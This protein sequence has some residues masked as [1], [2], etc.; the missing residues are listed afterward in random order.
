MLKQKIKEYKKV[1]EMNW[2]IRKSYYS[3][4]CKFLKWQY[5]NP[6]LKTKDAYEAKILRQAHV[7]EK[8]MSLSSPKKGFGV[9]K[10]LDLLNYIKE[11]TANG[12]RI[13]ES[14]AAINALGVLGAYVEFHKK[15]GFFPEEIENELKKYSKSI[16]D[17][18]DKFGVIESDL[19]D[20]RQLAQG[21]FQEFFKSRHSIRQFSKEPVTEEEINKAVS[22]AM[23]APS[24]CNRQSVKVYFYKDEATNKG[25]GNLIA[26]NTGFENETSRYIVITSNVS[27]FYESFER[28]QM[29]IDGGI[30]ALALSESLHYYGIANCILQNGE[31]KEKDD[32]FRKVCQNIPENE[33]I[34]VF[35]AVGHYPKQFT[36]ASSQRKKLS[37][38]LTIK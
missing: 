13:E 21:N 31:S 24:A 8:G 32:E 33:K 38:I 15:R 12:Y 6:S 28:N 20:I 22:L 30:F 17:D 2:N 7:L 5:N 35:M 36:Y 29:Y 26:G 19:E 18:V 34:I 11:Y 3:D 10:A 27:A 9:R 14:Q 1:I 37:D 23:H 16:P 4:C 25:L